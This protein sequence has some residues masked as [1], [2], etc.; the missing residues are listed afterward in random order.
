MPTPESAA[1]R[2]DPS[3]YGPVFAGL[4]GEPRL[5]PLDAGRPNEELRDRL[6]SVS[7]SCCSITAIGRPWGR[8]RWLR[9]EA[10]WSARAAAAVPALPRASPPA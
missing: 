6:A 9:V 3:R 2:F 8:S 5:A 10:M 4:L 7:G 1:P